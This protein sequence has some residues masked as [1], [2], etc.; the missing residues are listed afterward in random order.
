MVEA[1]GVEGGFGDAF[2]AVMDGGDGGLADEPCEGSDAACG[3]L[4]EVLGVAGE[5]AGFVLLEV[6]GVLDIGD[7]LAEGFTFAV[8]GGEGAAFD[9]GGA[10]GELG[11]SHAGEEGVSVTLMPA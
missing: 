9:D 3:A 7:A 2:G 5:G 1:D 6:E 4:V 10:S 8:A 11:A